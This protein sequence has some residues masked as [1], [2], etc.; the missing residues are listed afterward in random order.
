MPTS[1]VR[2]CAPELEH[3]CTTLREPSPRVRSVYSIYILQ[4][5]STS[6][7]FKRVSVRHKVEDQRSFYG[8]YKYQEGCHYPDQWV[9]AMPTLRS[10]QTI[11]KVSLSALTPKNRHT[12]VTG[13]TPSTAQ[14]LS[15]RRRVHCAHYE[16]AR[17]AKY[18]PL[19]T[20]FPSSRGRMCECFLMAG[21]GY[22]FP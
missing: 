4:Q 10:L 17:R 15:D 18:Y 6:K 12:L 9:S 5:Y 21:L 20:L 14:L 19:A 16:Y 3:G 8:E 13:V 22:F 7:S 1:V 11:V 2:S